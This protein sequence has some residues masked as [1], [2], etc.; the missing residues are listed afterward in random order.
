MQVSV[1]ISSA[2]RNDISAE[3]R[4]VSAILKYFHLYH[5][6]LGLLDRV[7]NVKVSLC[8]SDRVTD[9]NGVTCKSGGKKDP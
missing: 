9:T 6:L 3:D 4:P 5:I 1:E 8:I 7:L 2:P